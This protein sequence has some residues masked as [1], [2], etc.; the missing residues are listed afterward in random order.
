MSRYKDRGM[1]IKLTWRAYWSLFPGWCV[2]EPDGRILY[3]IEFDSLI[4][5]PGHYT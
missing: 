3:L 4:W 2:I 1:K 5:W